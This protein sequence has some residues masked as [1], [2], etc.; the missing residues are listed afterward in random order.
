MFTFNI[1]SKEILLNFVK[2]RYNDFL[3][4]FSNYKYK[5]KLVFE[6]YLNLVLF[7]KFLEKHDFLFYFKTTK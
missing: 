7:L 2:K 4:T 6:F 5:N 1:D 3:G